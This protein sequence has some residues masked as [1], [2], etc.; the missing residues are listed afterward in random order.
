MKYD[1]RQT[2]HKHTTNT[3]Q[4]H[5]KHTTNTPQTHLHIKRHIHSIFIPLYLSSFT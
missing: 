5:H 1:N 4:T 2:H 3:P